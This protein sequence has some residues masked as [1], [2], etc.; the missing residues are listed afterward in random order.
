MA[1]TEGSGRLIPRQPKYL[2]CRGETNLPPRCSWC[3]SLCR[4]FPWLI[5]RVD[6]LFLKVIEDGGEEIAECLA[7]LESHGFAVG[8]FEIGVIDTEHTSQVVL[9][10]VEALSSLCLDSGGEDFDFLFVVTIQFGDGGLKALGAL[11]CFSRPCLE[12]PKGQP[13][14]FRFPLPSCPV[15]R[16]GFGCGS[17]HLRETSVRFGFPPGF[18]RI[19]PCPP[20]ALGR[21]W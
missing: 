9:E 18:S 4:N 14:S 19:V 13:R 2:S 16:G 1:T 15:R 6:S 17:G 12:R 5:F 21:A 10:G 7:Q 11:L 20:V 8:H 3:Q